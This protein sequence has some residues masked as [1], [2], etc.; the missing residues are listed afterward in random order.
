M[1]LIS[2]ESD[3][4]SL[5][6]LKSHL[7]IDA[8][9]TYDDTL[10]Q[11]YLDT[12]L[13]FVIRDIYFD[14][15]LAVYEAT[16]DELIVSETYPYYYSLSIPTWIKTITIENPEGTQTYTR[17]FFSL[18]S[19]YDPETNTLRIYEEDISDIISVTA[20]TGLNASEMTP[21]TQARLLIIGDWFRNR[22]DSQTVQFSSLPNGSKRLL[23]KFRR[24]YI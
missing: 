12:S 4:L 14:P 23:D 1:D 20:T 5:S 18:R 24:S 3:P 13:E 2:Q 8:D 11:F 9:D 15:R 10:L 19:T 6:L 17:E 21:I 7:N 22:E 16:E